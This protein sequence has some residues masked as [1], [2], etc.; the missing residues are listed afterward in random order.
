MPLRCVDALR[1]H[2]TLMI[3]EFGKAATKPD[4]LVFPSRSGTEL[5]LH[6][7]RRQFR[8]VLQ[9]AGLPPKDWTLR[10]MRHT[11]VSLLSDDGMPLENIARLVGHRGSAVTE[12]VY[13]Q[14]LRP[15][16]EDGATAMDRIFGDS[17]EDVEPESTGSEEGGPEDTSAG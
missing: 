2:E 10:E 17:P 12:L 5:D 14:Q 13:R 6:N 1:S 4:A 7:L 11:F 9:A 15:V 3:K 16:L 8:Q